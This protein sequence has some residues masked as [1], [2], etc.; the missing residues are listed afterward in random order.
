MMEAVNDPAFFR[1]VILDGKIY[2]E[3]YKGAFLISNKGLVHH[4]GLCAY[5]SHTIT[6]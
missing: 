1:L 6:Y 2:M 5:H 4:M 3:K